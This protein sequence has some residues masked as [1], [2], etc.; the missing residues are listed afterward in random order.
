MLLQMVNI[1]ETVSM[2]GGVAI[3]VGRSVMDLRADYLD[4][5]TD[6][7][8]CGTLKQTTHVLG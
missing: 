5:C 3:S 6:D 8:S 4:V 2:G 1:G 7:P